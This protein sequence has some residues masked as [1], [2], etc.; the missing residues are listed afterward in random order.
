MSVFVSVTVQ[1]PAK[2]NRKP[3]KPINIIFVE[4]C[5]F[6]GLFVG[7]SFVCVWWSWWDFFICLVL[8]LVW[9]FLTNLWCKEHFSD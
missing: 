9:Y 1:A 5:W 4:A 8:G 6:F 3:L 7:V 2:A